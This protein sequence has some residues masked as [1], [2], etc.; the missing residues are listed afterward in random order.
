MDG[1]MTRADCVSECPDQADR[2]CSDRGVCSDGL[3]GNG[4]CSCQVLVLL[5]EV[6][7]ISEVRALNFVN[8]VWEVCGGQ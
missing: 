2:P 8:L 1:G 5:E 4:T 7:V 6:L 3:G